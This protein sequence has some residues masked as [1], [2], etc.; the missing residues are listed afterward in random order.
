MASADK[1]LYSSTLPSW[2]LK[3]AMPRI[4]PTAPASILRCWDRR[5]RLPGRTL[6]PFRRY[7][8]PTAGQSSGRAASL[9]PALSAYARGVRRALSAEIR[10]V[11]QRA[12][13]GPAG[14][15]WPA[16]RSPRQRIR[17]GRGDEALWDPVLDVAV[18]VEAHALQL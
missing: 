5:A 8:G 4:S 16:H 15:R 3:R 14:R 6:R 17:A 2:N 18:T 7:Y 11:D 10:I 12:D 9:A 13:R 1:R